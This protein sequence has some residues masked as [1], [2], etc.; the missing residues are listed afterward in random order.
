L[1]SLLPSDEELPSWLHTALL[2]G[3]VSV[4]GLPLIWSGAK[5][6]LTGT[7][8]PMSGPDFGAWFI[9]SLPLH[10]RSARVGGLA[11]VVLGMAFPALGLSW[12]HGAAERRLLK[13]AP[14]GLLALGALLMAWAGALA[15]P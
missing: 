9:S 15:R 6:L 2:L 12:T 5:A 1:K 8:L 4:F 7:M 14:W 13:A 3:L 10:G 11:L